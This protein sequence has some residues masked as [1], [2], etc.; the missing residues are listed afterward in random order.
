MNGHAAEIEQEKRQIAEKEQLYY[1]NYPN[2]KKMIE[3]YMREGRYHDITTLF[4]QKEV[5]EIAQIDNDFAVFNI[6]VNIYRMELNEHTSE[7]IWDHMHTM[8]DMISFYLRLKMY[9]WRFEFTEDQTSF[10]KYASDKKITIPCMKWLIHT[11]SFKKADTVYK[12]AVW[13]KERQYFVQAFQMILYLNELSSEKELIYCEM[14]DIYIQLH[15]YE[16]AC[17]CIKKIQCPTKLLEQYKQRWG[18]SLE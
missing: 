14:A 18:V 5:L 9:L 13:Y 2:Y 3:R 8:K 7:H 16:A 17:E 12:I 4:E 1:Q 6:I 10:L 11:S 15:K